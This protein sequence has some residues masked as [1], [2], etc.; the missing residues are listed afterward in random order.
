MDLGTGMLES[1]Y[2]RVLAH[3][4]KIRGLSVQCQAP[5][6]IIYED[7]HVPGAFV[8]DMVVEEKV[9]VELK[10][11]T[12]VAPVHS[13]QL[14]TYLKLSTMRLGLLVNF[15]EQYIGSGITRVVNGLS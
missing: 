7:L 8:A 15:G 9:I 5:I 2:E 10:S 12:K 3:E 13:K 4:L 11:V 6:G 14:L 1:A